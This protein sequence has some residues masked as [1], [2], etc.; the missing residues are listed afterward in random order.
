MQRVR[1]KSI[2]QFTGEYLHDQ[3]ARYGKVTSASCILEDIY[4][5]S[6][7]TAVYIIQRAINILSLHFS[8]I[9]LFALLSTSRRMSREHTRFL[10]PTLTLAQSC[11]MRYDCLSHVNLF[12]LSYIC[13]LPHKQQ[14]RHGCMRSYLQLSQINFSQGKA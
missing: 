13:I 7:T 3:R 2:D 5:R 11:S 8:H 12:S 6:A 4:A 9:H 10:I 1:S 14:A